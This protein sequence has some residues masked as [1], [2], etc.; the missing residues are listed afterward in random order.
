MATAM[1]PLLDHTLT[2]SDAQIDITN[3]PT[4]GY[5]DLILLM[6]VKVTTGIT[7]GLRVNGDSGTNYRAV[8]AWAKSTGTAGDVYDS[9]AYR[10]MGEAGNVSTQEFEVAE[11]NFFN[12]RDT[13][14]YKNIITRENQGSNITGFSVCTWYSL[15]AISSISLFGVGGSSF[16]QGSKFTLYGVVG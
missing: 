13:G 10:F 14:K 1:V 3:L 15:S 4:S 11:L 2:G 9:N 8:W 7:L 5:K 6:S 12:Y 16:A